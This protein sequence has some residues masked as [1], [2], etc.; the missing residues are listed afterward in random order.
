MKLK[1]EGWYDE[2]LRELAFEY[3]TTPTQLIIDFIK[4]HTAQD[5]RENNHEEN[6]PR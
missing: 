1:F 5:A 6:Q 3:N 4:S 2:R